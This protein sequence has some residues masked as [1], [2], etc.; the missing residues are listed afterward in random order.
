MIKATALQEMTNKSLRLKK[1]PYR[2][3]EITISA[4]IPPGVTFAIGRIDDVEESIDGTVHEIRATCSR[5]GRCGEVAR[6][7]WR[8]HRWDDD[9]IA[10]ARFGSARGHAAELERPDGDG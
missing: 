7:R 6:A 2:I 1:S 9:A 5:R 8:R 3:S 4:S 10:E